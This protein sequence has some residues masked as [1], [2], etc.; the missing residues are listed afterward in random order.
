MEFS[1]DDVEKPEAHCPK[2]GERATDESLTEVR[3]SELGYY[4]GDAHYECQECDNEW[5][6]GVPVGRSEK[7]SDDLYCQSCE[8]EWYLIHRVVPHVQVDFEEEDWTFNQIQLH[9]KC[10]NCYHFDRISREADEE[11]RRVLVGY[12]QIT[13]Q[14]EGAEPYGYKE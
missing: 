7:F 1:R 14:T 11:N 9:V 5:V 12:P 4:H 2:C 13:G 3:L 10:P 8:E 6:H